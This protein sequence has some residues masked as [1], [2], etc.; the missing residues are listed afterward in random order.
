MR[1]P[2]VVG[3]G[4][5]AALVAARRRHRPARV[6]LYLASGDVRRVVEPDPALGQLIPKSEA[7]LDGS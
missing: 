1:R 5:V 4:L 6:D 3:V 2:F 7:I